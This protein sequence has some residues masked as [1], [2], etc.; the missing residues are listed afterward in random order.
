MQAEYLLDNL[1]FISQGGAVS[2]AV[3]AILLSMSIGSW[4][5]MVT[6]AIQ[7]RC[8]KSSNMVFLTRFWQA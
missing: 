5:L 3:A 7:G 4:T 2:I 1:K 8:L 6:K